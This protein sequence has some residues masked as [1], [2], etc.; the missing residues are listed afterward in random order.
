MTA[1]VVLPAR[2]TRGQPPRVGDSVPAD[3]QHVNAAALANAAK[4]SKLTLTVMHGRP[5]VDLTARTK[6]ERS[7]GSV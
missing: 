4:L 7:I 2:S 5:M 6:A 3:L 1:Q